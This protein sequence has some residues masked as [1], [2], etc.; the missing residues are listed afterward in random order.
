MT[1]LEAAER[2]LEKSRRPMRPDEIVN[3]A[4][5]NG[6]IVPA[7][8]TPEATMS[9]NLAVS[10]K[11]DSSRFVR[12]APGVFGLAGIKYDASS[13]PVVKRKGKADNRQKSDECGYVY[14]LTNPSFRRDWVKIGMTERPVNTRS[15][16]LDNTAVPLPF[17]IYAT[18]KTKHRR[19]IE[20]LLHGSIDDIAPRKRIRKTREFFNIAPETALRLLRRAAEAF[21]EQGNIE[22]FFRKIESKSSASAGRRKSEAN[23]GPKGK[24]QFAKMIARQGGNEGAFGG[25]LQYLSR[26]RKCTTT[27]KW[28]AL[29]EQ[30]G[31]KFDKNDLVVGW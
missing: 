14:I 25:I 6:W 7:G 21:D 5:A 3:V 10:I 20:H 19:K 24:T 16:E 30:A 13:L 1:F 29:L 9:A 26:K 11:K 31:V 18:L 15:K 4:I 23:I 2:A 22:E 27:S 12:V 8:K 28:R 17:E